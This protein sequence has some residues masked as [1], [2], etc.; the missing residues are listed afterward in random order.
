MGKRLHGSLF[1][2]GMKEKEKEERRGKES[3]E[4]EKEH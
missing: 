2:T 4:E 1:Y 3:F